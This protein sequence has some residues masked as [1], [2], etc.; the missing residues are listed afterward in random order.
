[1]YLSIYWTS[2]ITTTEII[3]EVMEA[4]YT[5]NTVDS[6]QDLYLWFIMGLDVCH[7]S[8]KTNVSDVLNPMLH[9]LFPLSILIELP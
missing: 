3:S 5:L 1:M 9:L 6:D 4:I 2:I 7:L 8:Y